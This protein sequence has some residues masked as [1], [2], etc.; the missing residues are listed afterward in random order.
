MGAIDSSELLARSV[1]RVRILDLLCEH[2]PLEKHT[3]GSRLDASR[4]TVGRDLAA[5]ENRERKR[6]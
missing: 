3:L 5:L 1:H 2:G 6:P 4:T